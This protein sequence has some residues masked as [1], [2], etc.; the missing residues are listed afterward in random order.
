MLTRRVSDGLSPPLIVLGADM[1]T[2]AIV[3]ATGAVGA[4]LLAVLE[5]RNYPIKKLIPMASPRSVGTSIRF[6]G[7]DVA[8]QDTRAEGFEG[9]DVAFFSAGATRSREFVPAA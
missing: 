5:R 9:V 7:E 2:V 8:V 6:R 1:Q 4:E 3:G